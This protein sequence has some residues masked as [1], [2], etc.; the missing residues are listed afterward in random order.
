MYGSIKKD[1]IWKTLTVIYGRI[2]NSHKFQV[3]LQTLA[4]EA[5]R[6]FSGVFEKQ[7]LSGHHFSQ[8][9][10]I[11]DSKEN[12]IKGFKDHLEKRGLKREHPPPPAYP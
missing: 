7:S 11:A 6:M 10:R 8:G 2:L 4:W 5:K 12:Q 1:N 3:T 9:T